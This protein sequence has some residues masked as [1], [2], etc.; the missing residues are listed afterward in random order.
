MREMSVRGANQ[1]FSE[2]IAAA[3]AGETLV[4]TKNGRP[5]AK[6][7]RQPADQTEGPERRAAFQG[8]ARGQAAHARCRPR[9]C[10]GAG[11]RRTV[12]LVPAAFPQ[13]LRQVG[14]YRSTPRSLRAS[15]N[16]GLGLRDPRRSRPG[17]KI[18]FTEGM[19]DGGEVCELKLVNPLN[20]ENDAKIEAWLA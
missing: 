16:S 14:I 3:E 15:A 10:T 4:I 12:R 8:P 7:S 9:N 20:P 19:Q 18:L 1:N 13:A 2:V 6:I 11:S 5:V 17:A